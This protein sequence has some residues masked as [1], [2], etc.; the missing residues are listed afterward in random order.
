MTPATLSEF[1]VTEYL[2]SP[3]MM[4]AYIE[5]VLEDGDPQLVAAAPGDIST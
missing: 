4:A 2:N 1:D 3:E 5:A